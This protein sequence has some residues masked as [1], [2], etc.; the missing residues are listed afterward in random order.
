MSLRSLTQCSTGIRLGWQRMALSWEGRW[1]LRGVSRDG[2]SSGAGSSS[3]SHGESLAGIQRRAAEIRVLT[4][5]LAADAVEQAV[6][7]DGASRGPAISTESGCGP[8]VLAF[9]EHRRRS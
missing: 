1:S 2:G 3:A 8:L 4:V 7:A 6:A 5:A 9:G